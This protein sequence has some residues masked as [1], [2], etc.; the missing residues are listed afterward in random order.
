[1]VALFGCTPGVTVV[2]ECADGADLAELVRRTH[3]Q[4]AIVDLM[5]PRVDGLEATR[6]A[7]AVDPDLRVLLLTAAF[8]V[9]AV[10]E[11]HRLGA[12]GY[13]LKDDPPDVLLDAVR[14]VAAGGTAWPLPQQPCSGR[15]GARAS[16]RA[17][18][19]RA[20]CGGARTRAAG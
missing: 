9:A 16:V 10:R 3:P 17:P 15:A 18:L 1:L 13:Q 6:R 19:G 7:L 5:M 12:V 11:A 2:G 20:G 4:V 8:S 14:T